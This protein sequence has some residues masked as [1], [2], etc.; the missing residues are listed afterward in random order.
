MTTEFVLLSEFIALCE[1]TVN[2]EPKVPNYDNLMEAIPAFKQ[3]MKEIGDV[4]IPTEKLL[5][6]LGV[7]N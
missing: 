3:T 5:N 1:M 7:K 4:Q 2:K 6:L